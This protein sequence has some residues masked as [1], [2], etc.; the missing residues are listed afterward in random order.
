MYN[1]SSRKMFTKKNKRLSVYKPKL[2]NILEENFPFM[3]SKK[4]QNKKLVCKLK[5][6]PKPIRKLKKTKYNKTL[7]R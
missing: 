3:I 7:E 2:V 6:C 1:H 5:L 4:K